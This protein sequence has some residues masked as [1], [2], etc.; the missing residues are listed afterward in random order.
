MNDTVDYQVKET[1]PVRTL[2]AAIL[3]LGCAYATVTN[4]QAQNLTTPTTP[5]LITPPAGNSAFLVGHAQGTQG[6]V[7]LPTA[8]GASTASWTVNAARPEATLFQS[9]S[10]TTSRSSPTSSAPIQI[11]TTPQG[12][13]PSATRR[14]RVRLIAARY[15]QRS[16]MEMRSLPAPTWRVAPTLARLPVFYWNRLVRRKGQQAEAS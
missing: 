10:E 15:G 4:V 13:C 9:F 7:C 3:V 8:V 16:C 1:R 14:G 11:P 2:I 5:A 6:Y 12:R